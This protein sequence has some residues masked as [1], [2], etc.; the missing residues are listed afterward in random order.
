[1]QIS[2]KIY[3]SMLKS[4]LK[5]L[6][7]LKWINCMISVVY[8]K[9]IISSKYIIF[10]L[11]HNAKLVAFY[12]KQDIHIDKVGITVWWSFITYDL[13]VN[14]GILLST[15]DS[16]L[17]AVI[18]TTIEKVRMSILNMFNFF[19]FCILF[20]HEISTLMHVR[21]VLSISNFHGF[22]LQQLYLETKLKKR[23]NH[24][25]IPNKSVG[26]LSIPFF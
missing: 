15:T 26:I 25:I 12:L 5:Y 2:I 14:L 21:I 23:N 10:S 3:F 17:N 20:L 9:N 7:S 19:I 18:P 16:K 1:M 22:F 4:C 8:N 6:L 13:I 11:Y 24:R